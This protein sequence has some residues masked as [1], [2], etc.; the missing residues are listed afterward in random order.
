[1][2]QNNNIYNIHYIS[3]FGTVHPRVEKYIMDLYI[4]ATYID[5][6]LMLLTNEGKFKQEVFII[7]SNDLAIEDAQKSLTD[8]RCCSVSE[9]YLQKLLDLQHYYYHEKYLDTVRE[10]KRREQMVLQ[11]RIM[12]KSIESIDSVMDMTY[13]FG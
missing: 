1:M 11:D 9:S 10:F 5:E 13:I 4:M 2:D 12:S 6:V 3:R 8:G 7:W